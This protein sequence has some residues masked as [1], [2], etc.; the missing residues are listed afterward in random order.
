MN[1]L[2]SKKKESAKLVGEFFVSVYDE[3]GKLKSMRQVH[4]LIT[5]TGFNL[6]SNLLGQASPRPAATNFVAIGSGIVAAAVGDTALGFELPNSRLTGTYTLGSNQYTM[7]A[8]F[9]PG[10][11]TGG[12]TESGMLNASAAGTLFNR[13]VFAVVNKA[14][15]DT[16]SVTWTVS[17]S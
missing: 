10:T 6:V 17:L 12:V 1:R 15:G 5:T 11:G 3:S 13:Q 4:N 9:P 16:L 8:S 14:A 2:E 7:V